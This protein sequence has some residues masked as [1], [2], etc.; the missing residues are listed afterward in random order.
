MKRLGNLLKKDIS[1]GIKDVWILLEVGFSVVVAALLLFVIPESIERETAAYIYDETGIVETFVMDFVA[2]TGAEPGDTFV[3]SRA[4]VI[5]GMRD[6]RAAVGLLIAH[7]EAGGDYRVELLTQPYTTRAVVEYIET[8]LADLMSI[9]K[10]PNGAYP[11]DVYDYVRVT[12]LQEGLRDDLPFNQ[13]LLPP[14]ILYMVGLVGLFAMVSLVSQERADATLRAYKVSPASIWTFVTSKHLTLLGVAIVT[15]SVLYLPLMGVAGYLPSLLLILLT[16]LI[17]SAIGLMLGG[18]YDNPIGAMAWIFPIM[19]L[20]SLPMVSLLSPRFSPGWL[21]VLPSYHTLFGM[22][23][24]MFPDN[25][26]QVIWE[27]ALI[28]AIVAVVL[29]LVSGAF[30]QRQTRK[31]A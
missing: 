4:A 29:V 8:D 5:D 15:F 6:D 24:A 23:A 10:P 18:V 21:R 26:T 28:L 2:R 31:E 17:G 16:V 9:L 20:W 25:N 22:D 14:V 3:A 13:R 1:L 7:Q 27:S 19:I 12:S 30:Y 11:G